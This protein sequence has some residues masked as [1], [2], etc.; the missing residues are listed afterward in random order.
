MNECCSVTGYS[1]HQAN[2]A[3]VIKTIKVS[4][5]DTARMSVKAGN[6]ERGQYILYNYAKYMPFNH[7]RTIQWIGGPFKLKERFDNEKSVS[8]WEIFSQNYV[9][10]SQ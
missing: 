7:L 8:E 4:G 9:I 5:N 1:G 6:G 10:F 3:L 2:N